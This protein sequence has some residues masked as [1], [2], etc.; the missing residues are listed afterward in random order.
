MDE[1]FQQKILDEFT[2]INNHLSIKITEPHNP[3]E[4]YFG[5]SLYEMIIMIEDNTKKIFA[6]L[7]RIKELLQK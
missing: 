1:V 3:T 7:S 6:E 5:Q 4:T 2:K